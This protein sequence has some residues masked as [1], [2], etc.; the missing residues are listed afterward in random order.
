MIEQK[1]DKSGHKGRGLKIIRNILEGY[2]NITL[3]TLVD[4]EIF[5]QTLNLVL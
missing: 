1:S 3:N 5:H 2:P 4:K